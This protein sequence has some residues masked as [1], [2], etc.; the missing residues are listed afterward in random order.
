M[1]PPQDTPYPGT[2][3]IH[4]DAGDTRQGIFRVHETLPVQAGALTLLYPK[5]IPGDHSPS[6]PVA[7]LAGLKLS[8]GGKAIIVDTVA[9]SFTLVSSPTAAGIYKAGSS[10]NVTVDI[11]EAITGSLTRCG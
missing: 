3:E 6:G 10:I 1:P 9:P 11:S 2:V 7:M 5:W 4:V 8:A